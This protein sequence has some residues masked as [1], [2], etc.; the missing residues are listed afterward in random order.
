MN[1]ITQSKT[2]NK[3]LYHGVMTEFLRDAFNPAG[4]YVF[5][6]SS[7]KKSGDE[8]VIDIN[9]GLIYSRPYNK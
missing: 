7:S 2:E 9:K 4:V 1:A 5:R 8:M 6:F 3:K